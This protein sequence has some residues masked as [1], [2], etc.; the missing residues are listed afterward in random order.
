MIQNQFILIILIIVVIYFI[1]NSHSQ[2]NFTYWDGSQWICDSFW[3]G[4]CPSEPPGPKYGKGF[5]HRDYTP[6]KNNYYG[7]TDCGNG[8]GTYNDWKANGG[9]CPD[10]FWDAD[11]CGTG[12]QKGGGYCADP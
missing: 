9:Q 3:G 10:G 1:S 7:G 11:W 2:E 4:Q 6:N 5:C 12:C 8:D